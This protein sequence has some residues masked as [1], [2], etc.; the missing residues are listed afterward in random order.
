MATWSY[1]PFHT[2]VKYRLSPSSSCS[3]QYT[4]PF[5]LRSNWEQRFW[6]IWKDNQNWILKVELRW[7]VFPFGNKNSRQ[8]CRRDAEATYLLMYSPV[9][10]FPQ[11]L[12]LKHP[13]CHCLS[14]ASNACPF[15]MSLPQPA[16][17]ANKQTIAFVVSYLV[18]WSSLTMQQLLQLV[19]KEEN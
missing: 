2:G 7:K 4:S 1:S 15:F 19:S 14:R 5:H 10:T 9:R 6:C 17:S 12:H 16:Q 11:A 8:E 3:F 18:H 13:R